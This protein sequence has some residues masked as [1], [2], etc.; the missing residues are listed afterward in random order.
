MK[1]MRFGIAVPVIVA[2]CLVVVA[3][4][5]QDLAMRERLFQQADE[6]FDAARVA[7]VDVLAPKGYAE[8]MSD[9]KRAETKFLRGEDV[10]G[11]RR[12]VA[13]ARAELRRA[14]EAAEIASITL[15]A[16][17]KAR[18]DAES[19]NAAKYSPELWT[20]AEKIY[21][22]RWPPRIG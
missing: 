21:L 15:S 9:Y 13:R 11:I 3:L 2:A 10:E 12:G 1:T 17:L 20:T 16:P 8:A 7:K 5:A 18:T 4:M 19:A 22:G 14:T 6:Q